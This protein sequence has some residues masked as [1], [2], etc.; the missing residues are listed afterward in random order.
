MELDAQVGDGRWNWELG[1]EGGFFSGAN[2]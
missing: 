2:D 1:A